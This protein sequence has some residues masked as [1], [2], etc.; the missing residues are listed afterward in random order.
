MEELFWV[1]IIHRVMIREVR[2]MVMHLFIFII[3]IISILLQGNMSF[4][5]EAVINFWSTEVEKDR[6]RIQEQIAKGF[7]IKTGVKV[8]IIPV[9]ENHLSEKVTA[10]Y[11]ARSLPDVIFHPIEFSLGLC[12]AGI[13]DERW[14][15]EVIEELDEGTFF[16]RALEMVRYKKGYAAVPADGWGQLLLY[17]KDLFRQKGLKTPRSWDLILEAARLLHSP[18]RLWGIEIA[19]DPGQIYTQQ[20]FEHFALSNN[21]TL[22]KIHS[23]E[24]LQTLNFYK[25]LSKFSPPGNIYWLHTRMDYLLGRAAMVIWSPFILDELSGLRSDQPVLPDIEKKQKGYLAKN[26]GFVG[27]IKGPNGSA[28][29]GQINCFGI[30]RDANKV[31]AEKW[32]KYLL[33]EGYLSWLG[34]AAEGK[35]PMRRGTKQNPLLFIEGWK[36]LEFGIDTRARISDRY[37]NELLEEIL[38]SVNGFSRWGLEQGRGLLISRLY[39]TKL[40]PKI[41]K[42]FLNNELTAQQASKELAQRIKALMKQDGKGR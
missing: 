4:G 34:M 13:F 35:L 36:G 20:V 38:C 41:L 21:V 42:R 31:Y 27:I 2:E 9:D 19:T 11:A 30:T 10:A 39:G 17:R 5:K 1:G 8:R 37:G 24:M 23:K 26:T 12:K 3:S 25:K 16:K 7:R 22:D 40:L 33:S 14:A 28:Q 29:Y 32:V 15:T 6:I 18:P